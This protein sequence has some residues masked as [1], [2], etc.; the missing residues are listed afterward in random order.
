MV[1]RGDRHVE[2]L[3]HGESIRAPTQGYKL[4]H[5]I[6]VVRPDRPHHIARR[7]LRSIDGDDDG[8]SLAPDYGRADFSHRPNKEIKKK[9]K[10]EN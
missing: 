8:I 7:R 4:I 9:R 2:D 1:G 6:R 5:A 3:D 10:E